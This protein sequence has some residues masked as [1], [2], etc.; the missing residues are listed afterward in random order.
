MKK[1]I[2][3]LLN[4]LSYLYCHINNA[5]NI[6]QESIGLEKSHVT[7]RM[8]KLEDTTCGLIGLA[9]QDPQRIKQN[10]DNHVST[11]TTMA[12]VVVNHLVSSFYHSYR[13]H[14]MVH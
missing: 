1:I 8:N 9:E 12:V 6:E 5:N 2:I 11:T 4:G 14:T 3:T 7:F 10:G 13:V